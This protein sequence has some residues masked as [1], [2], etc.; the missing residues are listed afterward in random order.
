MFVY[1]SGT[2]NSRFAAEYMAKQVGD[3]TLNA[4]PLIKAGEKL[5]CA[6]E[7]PWVFAAPVYGWQLPR[8]F[9]KLIRESKLTGSK[10]AYFVLTCGSD[11]GSAGV[12]ARRLC[13]DMGLNYRGILEVV[14]PENYLAMFPVPQ[15]EDW[16]GIVEKAL[17]VL[18][19]GAEC[20][21]LGKDFPEK[22]TGFMDDLKSGMVNRLFYKLFVKADAFYAKDSC[23]G[24][25]KCVQACPMNNVH[26]EAGRPVWGNSCTHCMACICD[27][28]VEAIE[29]GKKS[30]GKPR[31][32]C[33]DMK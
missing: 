30:V 27:C 31:Y 33:P 3:E 32:H 28:P 29:Y 7:K 15:R 1:F 22:K 4:N 21:R 16:V 24:C 13:L 18:V 20:V 8:V 5:V 11:I 23:I 26:L 25:G 17:P 9:E 10:D 6:S 19:R 2:G 12:Y 14:M